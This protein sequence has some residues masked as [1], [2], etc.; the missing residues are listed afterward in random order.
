MRLAVAAVLAIVFAIIFIKSCKRTADQSDVIAVLKT[1]IAADSIE[2]ATNKKEFDS[3]IIS[4]GTSLFV[5]NAIRTMVED[6][7][8]DANKRIDKLLAKH[9]SIAVDNDT[10]TT[11]CPN[12]FVNECAECFE[13]LPRYKNLA[14]SFRLRIHAED[15]IHKKQG[16][17]YQLRIDELGKE[18]DNV[19]RSLNECLGLKL[20]ENQ[21]AVTGILFAHV[22]AL[23]I[24]NLIPAA[25]GGGF[26]YQDRKLKQYGFNIYNSAQGNI[27]MVDVSTP[28]IK[29]KS[30]KR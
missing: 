5:A 10:G 18:K 29:F 28:I 23:R 1:K 12:E 13:E 20:P 27:Y 9:K 11:I 6:S 30:K 8:D 25:F 15:S 3:T 4:I 24:N 21:S 26:S 7:L 2:H 17:A 14:N 19:N 22:S 16:T